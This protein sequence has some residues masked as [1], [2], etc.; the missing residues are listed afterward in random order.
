MIMPSSSRISLLLSRSHSCGRILASSII[1]TVAKHAPLVYAAAVS[2]SRSI[3]SLLRIFIDFSSILSGGTFC[4]GF[5]VHY[6]IKR[7]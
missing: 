1:A 5:S 6:F 3:F 7:L 4:T 2:I